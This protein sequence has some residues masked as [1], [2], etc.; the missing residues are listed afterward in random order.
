MIFLTKDKK[1]G[2]VHIV[3]YSRVKKEKERKKKRNGF[4]LIHASNFE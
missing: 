3:C 1:Q 2:V 4:S